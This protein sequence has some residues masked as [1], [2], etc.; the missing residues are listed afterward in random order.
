MTTALSPDARR[1]L[2]LLDTVCGTPEGY[3]LH[4]NQHR[5]PCGPCA[6]AWD[7]SPGCT[8]VRRP[9]CGTNGGWI[10]HR[11][12]QE[13]PCQSCAQA[14]DEHELGLCGTYAGWMAHRKNG[15]VICDRC[16]DARRA[17]QAQ[18]YAAVHLPSQRLVPQARVIRV[19]TVTGRLRRALLDG[20]TVVCARGP[21]AGCEAVYSPRSVTDRYPWRVVSARGRHISGTDLCAVQPKGNRS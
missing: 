8:P 9:G 2:E 10:A 20:C 11:K 4:R 21:Y 7:A 12:R 5:V 13:W 17:Y 14:R 16:D 3:R 19:E 18:R 15:S 6:R 1:M